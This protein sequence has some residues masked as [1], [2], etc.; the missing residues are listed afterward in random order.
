M[1]S[2]WG[3]IHYQYMRIAWEDTDE[4]RRLLIQKRKARNEFEEMV[5]RCEM[6]ESFR[7]FE[8]KRDAP[9]NHFELVVHTGM[10]LEPEYDGQPDYE[11]P[12]ESLI[13][14]GLVPLCTVESS[15]T[16]KKHRVVSWKH[17]S[18]GSFAGRIESH[19]LLALQLL[20]LQEVRRVRKAMR[21]GFTD[22]Q[23]M[24]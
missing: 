12:R 18:Y 15:Y 9:L 3:Q 8:E 13:C 10:M 7:R 16:K 20:I 24:E 21:E 4:Y 5:A 23:H 1:I 6:R 11:R 22:K 17:K 2:I 14:L 19:S